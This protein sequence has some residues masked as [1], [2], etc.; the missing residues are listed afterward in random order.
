MYRYSDHRWQYQGEYREGQQACDRSRR[1]P[2][3]E[4]PDNRDNHTYNCYNLHILFIYTANIQ[5]ISDTTKFFKGN[6]SV[7]ASAKIL[8]FLVNHN[9]WF[10]IA[11]SLS[12][13]LCLCKKRFVLLYWFKLESVHLLITF[14][15]RLGP[16]LDHSFLLRSKLALSLVVIEC[17]LILW[18]CASF[19]SREQGCN[20]I[21]STS[22]WA[23]MLFLRWKSLINQLSTDELF[24]I[25]IQ[26]KQTFRRKALGYD[27]SYRCPKICFVPYSFFVIDSFSSANIRNNY[28][29]SKFF[30][31]N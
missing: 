19:C 27:L 14:W 16:L 12:K 10:W 1:I 9:V 22:R 15:F 11:F 17:S 6:L 3:T 31:L 2:G 5:I 4:K 7:Y 29:S 18:I 25:T 24:C 13:C 23:A 30:L 20:D 8:F 28:E 26:F 21:C